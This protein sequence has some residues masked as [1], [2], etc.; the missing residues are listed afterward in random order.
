MGKIKKIKQK[1]RSILRSSRDK[2]NR[3]R[4][5][6][7][8]INIISANCIGG[9]IYHDLGLK[10]NS[11]TVNLYFNASDYV[12]FV[13]NLTY[14]LKC[15]LKEIDSEFDYP[16]ALCG[17]IVLHMVHYHSF[18][19]GK[20]KWEERI[21][22]INYENLYFIMV[23]RDGCEEKDIIE[24]DNLKYEHKVFLT[25]KEHP[26]IKCAVCIPKSADGNQIRDLC[27]FKSK[28][29]GE[30]WLD[31]FDYVTFLNKR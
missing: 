13:S 19:E 12:K 16:C 6:N 11:P 22:R 27:Q 21:K 1:Y 20:K 31:E 4:L 18:E 29:T 10:F 2:E 7:E 28:F 8:N 9:V 5:R 3:N 23:D 24:F 17:D 25:Y 15:E 14:Y 26:E 30:R